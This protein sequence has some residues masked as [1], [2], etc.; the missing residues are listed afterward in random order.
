[1]EPAFGGFYFFR[2]DVNMPESHIKNSKTKMKKKFYLFL[3]SILIFYMCRAQTIIG[4]EKSYESAIIAE[5]TLQVGDT[6]LLSLASGNEF[7]YVRRNTANQGW[8]IAY[9][10]SY[11]II[12]YF[13]IH[14]SFPDPIVVAS[15]SKYRSMIAH[16][17]YL[18]AKKSGEIEL[19]HH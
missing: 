5:D 9:T 11:I 3:P 8:P 18:P 2:F 15:H 12:E 13:K 6:L 17:N 4:G 10:G 14:K 16:I 7:K 1:M 19:V